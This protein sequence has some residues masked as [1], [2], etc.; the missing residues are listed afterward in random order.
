MEGAKKSVADQ[1]E[2]CPLS[3][4]IDCRGSWACMSG[5]CTDKQDIESDK[6]LIKTFTKPSTPPV[7]GYT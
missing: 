2:Q 1:R 6:G 5:M 4:L 3:S 7:A